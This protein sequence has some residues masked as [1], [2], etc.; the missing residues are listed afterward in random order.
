MILI[1]SK[2]LEHKSL[3]APPFARRHRHARLRY[4]AISR[5]RTMVRSVNFCVCYIV[6]D[7]I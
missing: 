3:V 6:I 7:Q 4:T 1:V 5:T 2:K